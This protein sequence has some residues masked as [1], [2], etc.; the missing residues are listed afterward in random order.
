MR[1]QVAGD[2]VENAAEIGANQLERSDGGNRNQR[3]DKAVLDRSSAVFVLNEL[4]EGAEHLLSWQ[5][6]VFDGWIM[7]QRHLPKL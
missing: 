5:V 2:R 4:C 7:W 1:L 3:G 6:V